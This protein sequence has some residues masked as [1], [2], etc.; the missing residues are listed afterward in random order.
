MTTQPEARI[1][2]AILKAFRIAGIYCFKVHGSEY[3][4]AGL[5]DIIACVDG[6]FVGFEVKVP[7]KRHNTS[8]VQKRQHQL[9]KGAKGYSFVVCSVGEAMV[10]VGRI[11]TQLRLSKIPR[12][13][14]KKGK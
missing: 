3:M 6:I 9:I 14:R 2:R 8:E 11:R 10:Q 7:G 1:S 4:V 13:Q 12:D 5:P